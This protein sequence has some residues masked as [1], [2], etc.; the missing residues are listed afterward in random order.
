MLRDIRDLTDEREAYADELRRRWGA[1][2]SY[3]YIGRQY[4]S[5]DPRGVDDTV[6][7]RQDMPKEARR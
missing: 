7:L 4:A 1:L 6:T 2:L 5:M 3:R